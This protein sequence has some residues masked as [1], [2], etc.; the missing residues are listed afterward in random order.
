VVLENASAIRNIIAYT[1]CSYTAY[2]IIGA[3]PG[4]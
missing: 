2:M 4:G 3:A 1:L